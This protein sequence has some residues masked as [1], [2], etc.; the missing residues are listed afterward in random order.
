MATATASPF[1]S[2]LVNQ[3]KHK[4][5]P[6]STKV[7]ERALD[8]MADHN[9][10]RRCM[11]RM[12]GVRDKSVHANIEIASS[13]PKKRLFDG[14]EAPCTLCVGLLQMDYSAIASDALALLGQ[15]E[16]KHKVF[17]LR[18]QL[19]PQLPIRNV[20]LRK[21]LEEKISQDSAIDE[22]LPA[23]IEIREIFRY[24]VCESFSNASDLKFDVDVRVEI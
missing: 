5:I 14:E 18:M 16:L 17:S 1:I 12:V 8:L 22:D 4:C 13:I 9:I 24:L 15:Y 2:G 7:T 20:S 11:L 10:C 6:F 19:P 21:F 23:A 3:L